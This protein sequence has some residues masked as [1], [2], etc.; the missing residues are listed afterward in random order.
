MDELLEVPGME[1]G[2]RTITAATRFGVPAD[3][4]SAVAFLCSDE[5]EYIN[6]ADLAVDGGVTARLPIPE[7]RPSP[8]LR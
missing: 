7:L 6:G 2:F 8:T 1:D 3:I 4:A 5:A